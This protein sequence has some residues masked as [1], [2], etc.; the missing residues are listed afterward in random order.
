MPIN[1]LSIT[2]S[3]SKIKRK[4]KAIAFKRIKV[5]TIKWS[6]KN[7]PKGIKCMMNKLN[8]IW[9]HNIKTMIR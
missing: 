7:T 4:R 8:I 6:K 1:L 5:E 2:V 3:K 9:Q